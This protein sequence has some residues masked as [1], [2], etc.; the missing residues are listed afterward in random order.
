MAEHGDGAN[1]LLGRGAVYFTPT[2]GQETFL[3]NCT[4]LEITTTDEL[5]EMYS[6]TEASSPLLK[7]VLIRRTM[8]I[9]LTLTEFTDLNVLLAL[10]GTEVETGIIAAGLAAT[11]EGALKFVGDPSAGP[12]LTLEA[13]KVALTPDG[14]LGLIS[15]E[16]GEIKLK[17]KV[18]SDAGTEEHADYPY[19]KVTTPSYSPTP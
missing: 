9:A 10:M 11:M 5:K 15:D 12:A 3:G 4:V 19:I 2:D 13:W 6:S 18:L 7:S 8:E 14:A 16:F 1:L 17:G